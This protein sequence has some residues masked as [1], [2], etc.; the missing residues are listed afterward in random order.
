M[1]LTQNN[2][3]EMF[4]YRPDTG[5]LLWRR[6]PRDHFNSDWKHKAW[7]KRYA[8]LPAGS[9]NGS[10]YLRATIWG[11]DYKIHRLVW[12]YVYGCEPKHQIDHI[13]HDRSD[14]RIKNLRSAKPCENMKN[15][16]RYKTN[17]SG[18]TGV[19]WCKRRC[20]WRA[21]I[22]VLGK[23]FDLG[24]FDSIEAAERA[25]KAAEKKNKFHFGHGKPKAAHQLNGR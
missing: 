6:R 15:K 10:G 11:K 5:V 14:N 25:R 9:D 22:R 20:K 17:T 24:S 1:E 7:N 2:L 19:H 13:N 23:G 18:V 4:D 16:S 21:F 3:I 8:G 12:L